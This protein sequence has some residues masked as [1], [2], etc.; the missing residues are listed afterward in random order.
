[1]VKITLVWSETNLLLLQSVIIESLTRH[2]IR[3]FTTP[4]NHPYT[5]IQFYSPHI[6]IIPSQIL[7]LTHTPGNMYS[8]QLTYHPAHLWDVVGNWS[9]WGK[10]YLVIG[11]RCKRY[12]DRSWGQV[13]PRS[14]ELRGS[15]CNHCVTVL[16]CQYLQ[17][18]WSEVL[19][20]PPATSA[21][22]SN[23]KSFLKTFVFNKPIGHPSWNLIDIFCQIFLFGKH[24]GAIIILLLHRSSDPG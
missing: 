7:P 11:R 12:T 5:L 1:M 10:S 17:I 15:V 4:I 3:S 16:S 9:T 19:E 6:L 24:R 14:L 23:F 8:N 21:P 20:F 18:L 2:G 13:K 22:L